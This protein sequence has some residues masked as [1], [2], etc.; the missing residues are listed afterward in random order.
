[1]KRSRIG[2]FIGKIMQVESYLLV[3]PFIVGLIYRESLHQLLAYGGVS[4]TLF[5][6]GQLLSIK[7]PESLKLTAREGLFCVALAWVLL[8]F[9][10]ALPLMIT[11][12]IPNPF[13]A[14][15]EVVSGFTTTG[16][17][18]LKDPSQLAHSSLFWR[19]FTHLIGGMGV[20]VFALAILP[21]TG[22]DAVQLMRAEVPGPVFGKLVSKLAQTARILYAIYLVMTAVL[23]LVLCLTGVPLFDSLLLSF[24]TAGTG[25]FGIH[26]D[27]LAIY[28]N[29]ELVEW[30]IGFGMMLFGVNFNIYYFILIGLVNEALRDEELKAYVGIMMLATVGVLFSIWQDVGNFFDALRISFF[31][32][33]SLMTT[34]GYATADFSKWI[35]PAQFI[36][37]LVMFIGGSAGSTAGGFKV[38]R[39]V[40][41]FKMILAEFRRVGQPRRVVA[42]NFN[43]KMVDKNSQINLAHYL[44]I[45][46]AVFMSVL[47]SVTFESGDFM[48]AFSASAATFNNI[49]PGLGQVGPMS[50]FSAYSDW[51]TL[52]LSFSMLAG[53][54]EIYPVL[55]LFAPSTIKALTKIKKPAQNGF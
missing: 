40:I 15:F 42:V 14:F 29:P 46:M 55:I 54:L 34:T 44:L 49:G 38:S 36:L 21:A 39:I 22:S 8:S 7:P 19:S 28:S 6:C 48:T 24:G 27:G 50:N 51:N 45:Y 52:V 32:V 37:L 17:S 12:E 41:Y 2:Y 43:R 23:V 30:I 31:N 13:D 16:S 26:P 33:S 5:I 10:G 3:L 53:R 35:L 18:I 4:L 20:L 47:F 25:G 11:G 1:M 9:F